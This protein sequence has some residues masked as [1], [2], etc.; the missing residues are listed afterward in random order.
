MSYSGGAGAQVYACIAH[1]MR[2]YNPSLYELYDNMCLL[3]LLNVRNEGLTFLMPDDKLTKKLQDLLKGG[4]DY[5]ESQA[6]VRDLIMQLKALCV[7]GYCKSPAELNGK[8][9]KL[10]QPVGFS[11]GKLDSGHEV[12]EAKEFVIVDM[13][14]ITTGKGDKVKP[15]ASLQQVFNLSGGDLLNTKKERSKLPSKVKGGHNLEL[16]SVS[17]YA[18]EVEDMW[19]QNFLKMRVAK[20]STYADSYLE[21]VLSYMG[22]LKD[23]HPDAYNEHLCC[24]D[25]IPLI[26]FYLI[27]KPYSGGGPAHYNEWFGATRG[28][29]ICVCDPLECYKV[30]LD[31]ARKKQEV[32]GKPKPASRQ[33]NANTLNE[34]VESLK[35][36]EPALI[37]AR[38]RLYHIINDIC[39]AKDSGDIVEQFNTL[40]GSVRSSL[41][42]KNMS[43]IPGLMDVQKL[44]AS[45]AKDQIVTIITQ[46]AQS[47]L[48]A[49]L[50]SKDMLSDAAF[51]DFSQVPGSIKVSYGAF[52]QAIMQKSSI[53]I[54]GESAKYLMS[55]CGPRHQ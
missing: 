45:G 23:K 36:G 29:F 22:F 38:Y 33:I 17:N 41:S 40:R 8:V 54:C 3:D 37:Y 55:L 5:K 10:I 34:F 2:E 32:S 35:E 16:N 19:I 9:N 26:S 11:G 18:V 15:R 1:Y 39:E 43:A 21:A 12:K 48:P 14:E 44:M 28:R 51:P 49:I 53:E 52:G 13:P 7:I 30:I 42:L 31:D 6:N 20:Q 50:E 25:F 27:F 4:K 46:L 24:M 47:D